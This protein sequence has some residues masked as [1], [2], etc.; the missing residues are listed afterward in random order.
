KKEK[1][2]DIKDKLT[3]DIAAITEVIIEILPEIVSAISIFITA[4]TAMGT[5]DWRLLFAG[6]AVFP[7]EILPRRVKQKINYN[8]REK[9]RE[10]NLKGSHFLDECLCVSGELLVK[11][12]TKEKASSDYYRQLNQEQYEMSKNQEK[13]GHFFSLVILILAEVN[14]ILVYLV[15]G[16]L[17]IVQGKDSVSIG[18]ITMCLALCSRLKRPFTM[19]MDSKSELL[20]GLAAFNRI[21][22]YLDR[23]NKIKVPENGIKEKVCDGDIE[24]HHVDFSY[25]E[26]VPLLKNVN[27][28]LEAGKTF[29][30]VGPSGAGKS[31]IINL[32]PRLYDTTGGNITFD[33]VDVKEID[34]EYL[35]RN[36]GVVSQE[37]HLFDGTILENLKY[38][39]E[40]ATMDEITE[41]CKNANIYDFIMSLP[42]GFN[43]LVGQKG[44]KLS[45]GEKQRIAIARVLLKNPKILILD[46]AT[47]ALDS[48]N[49][50]QIQEALERLLVG[51][52][53]IIIAHRLSTVLNAD[54]ILVIEDGQII[55]QGKHKELLA[56]NGV[57]TELFNTQFKKVLDLEKDSK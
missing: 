44:M 17:M 35:R 23:E 11:L 1:P 56:L 10:A 12:F 26:S 43:S 25:E 9:R 13:N 42:E 16:W 7:L 53:S 22:E 32:I 29:A 21:I 40:N 8:N 46:E 27:F 33:G 2:A 49:E 38:A 5:V 30:L 54:Q 52:T 57:Y 37:N 39:K 28:T 31:S 48:I 3:T 15:A 18:S 36:I 50:N 20:R 45:G 4:F 34:L 19:L 51:R 55:E 47:S 6:L 41:A 24:F 14:S